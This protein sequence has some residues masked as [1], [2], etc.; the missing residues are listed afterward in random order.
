MDIDDKLNSSL[1]TLVKE[2]SGGR[3][4]RGGGGS[5]RGRGRGEK[6][7]RND[8]GKPWFLIGGAYRCL[9]TLGFSYQYGC[10]GGVIR[11]ARRIYV[12]NLT[13]RTSWQDLKDHF[14]QA[15]NGKQPCSHASLNQECIILARKRVA[16]WVL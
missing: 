9:Q 12:S 2:S 10:A 4:S 15:G 16:A 5:G 8:T 6:R 1:D 14:K 13:W 3:P 7:E 11:V